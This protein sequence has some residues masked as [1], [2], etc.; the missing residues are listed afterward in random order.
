[1]IRPFLPSDVPH[2]IRIWNGAAER[3]EVLYKTLTDDLFHLLFASR[4]GFPAHFF[5]VTAQGSEAPVGFIH[6]VDPSHVPE[7]KSGCACLTTVFVDP[8]FRRRGLA[9]EMYRTLEKDL[10]SCGASSVSI[11]SVNPFNLPWIIPGTPGHDHNN[12]PGLD[13]DCP[14][15][16]FFTAL[17]FQS[18]HTEVAMYRPLS[19]WKLPDAIAQ[20]QEKLLGEHIRTG[21]YDPSLNC[22][23]DR[24]C[25]GVGSDYWRAV[26]R[27]EIHAW[28]TGEPNAEPRFWPDG[29]K[30]DGP[31]PL[32]TA[33]CGDQIVGFTGPVDLQQSG[34]GWFTGIC[35][36]P[37]FQHRG[38]ATV[39]FNLLMQ[40]FYEEGAAFSTLFTG[41]DNRAQRIYRAAGLRAVRQFDLMRRTCGEV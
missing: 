16:P 4:P 28:K 2:I 38:I 11:T 27:T 41:T 14:A 33:V 34:R 12:M 32:I 13:R 19:D 7:G 21:I 36:D 9:A 3:G 17:G 5:V 1:M 8:P 39:L 18:L 26:L 6:G 37:D 25:D 40:A 23:Y 15:Y 31:R 10:V 24:L 35:V 29:R 22:G 20:H 30:P